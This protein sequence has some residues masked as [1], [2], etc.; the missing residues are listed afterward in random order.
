M[1]REYHS[2]RAGSKSLTRECSLRT[3]LQIMPNLSRQIQPTTAYSAYLLIALRFYFLLNLSVTFLPFLPYRANDSIS[4]IPL[5]PSQRALMGLAPSPSPSKRTSRTGAPSTQGS[6]KS[7]TATSPAYVTPPRY[8]RSSF[9]P[10][11]SP[12]GTGDKYEFGPSTPNSGRSTS[13]NYSSSPLS[14]RAAAPSPD[15]TFRS[16]STSIHRLTNPLNSPFSPQNRSSSGSPLLQKALASN[17]NNNDKRD[18]DNEAAF[19]G[20]FIPFTPS[21]SLRRSQSV[22]EGAGVRSP[23]SGPGS[24]SGNLSRSPGVNYKWLYEQEKRNQAR[25]GGGS[26]LMNRS[27]SLQF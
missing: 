26:G 1:L 14:G 24:G 12:S 4:D 5:T 16:L 27:E 10:S 2:S 15:S 8:R 13:A 6:S 25:G 18:R 23:S 7:L 20:S 9:S 17:N 11:H 19:Q 3:I 21:S 22:R